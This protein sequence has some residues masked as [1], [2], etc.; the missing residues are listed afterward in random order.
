VRL[1]ALEAGESYYSSALLLL[2]K[3]AIRERGER[4]P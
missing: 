4:T 3:I 1:P 2:T